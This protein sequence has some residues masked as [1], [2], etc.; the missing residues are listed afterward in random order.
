MKPLKNIR[1]TLAF[2]GSSYHGWQIQKKHPT[3]QGTVQAALQEITGEQVNLIGSGRTDAGTHARGLVAN[4]ITES[5][6]EPKNL[7][8]ALNSNLPQDIRLLSAREAPLNFHARR[9]AVTK[10]YRY[11]IYRGPVM[12]PHLAREHYHFPYPLD[13]DIMQRASKQ[14]VGEHDFG[15]FAGKAKKRALSARETCGADSKSPT[16]TTRRHIF[17]CNLKPVGFRLIL[18]VEGSG[19]LHHMVRNMVGTLLELATGKLNI[20]QFENLFR[21]SDRTK[22]GFT[23]PAHGLILMRVRY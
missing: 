2:D 7:A 9:S 17:R 5:P 13:I 11:Q 22:A 21:R 18:T 16:S 1:L 10:I 4:F 20:D 6:I 3:I 8:R 23:A 19:F 12:P 14:F 15:S